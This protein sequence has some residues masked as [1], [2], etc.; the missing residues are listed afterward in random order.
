MRVRLAN[1]ED[2]QEV[3]D[4]TARVKEEYFEANGIPQWTDDYPAEIDFA[5]DL[6]AGR[7]FVMHMGECLI[8]YASMEVAEDPCY[9]E[10]EGG[11]WKEEGP[12]VLIHRF[13]IN[14]DWHRMG[15]GT[16]LMALADKLA[17]AKGAKSARSDTHE[18]NAGMIALL[19]KCGFEKRGTI[20][21]EDGSPRIAFEKDY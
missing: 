10:I 9:G 18:K 16:V 3:I 20:H 1:E 5:R 17:E 4:L 13:A 6:Q 14:P 19:E 7:L 8:G 21:L 11:S 12:Y 2:L 15:M